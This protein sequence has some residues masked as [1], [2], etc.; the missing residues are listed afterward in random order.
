[1]SR[2][3]RSLDTLL[4]L[5]LLGIAVAAIVNVVQSGGD[6]ETVPSPPVEQAPS[7]TVATE[8]TETAAELPSLLPLPGV[9]REEGGVLWWSDAQCRAGSLELASGVVVS[10]PAAHCRLWP[11]PDGSVAVALSARRSDALEGRGLVLARDRRGEDEV[12]LGHSP[13]FLGSEL[14]W[15]PFGSTFA[16]CFETRRGAVVDVIAP[17][18]TI[19][20]LEGACSP[21]WLS[22]GRLA[23]ARS[24]PLSIEVDGRVVLDRKEVAELL[25]SVPRGATRAVSALGAGDG[26]VVAGL[27]A[28]SG[29]RLLPYTA[30]LVILTDSGEIEFT[31]QLSPDTL[32]AAVGLSPDGRAL[33]YFDGGER[34]AVI[35]AVPGGSRLLPF[36][37]RWVAWSPD[38]RYLAAA[39]GEG[40][41]ISSWPDGDR[42]AEVPV[43]ANDVSWS[44]SP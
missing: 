10:F 33:W 15:N 13:G 42:V 22:D 3:A 36:G 7:P 26:R 20:T 9:L 24:S 31:A 28:V 25:P 32:P 17:G 16:V 35:I 39:T 5:A 41:V 30:S 23:V 40:I 38:G 27:V 8:T 19:G 29:K 44:R 34:T 43:V 12:V 1:M 2:R 18:Q 37:A 14:S 6:R 21:A 11:A 4:V